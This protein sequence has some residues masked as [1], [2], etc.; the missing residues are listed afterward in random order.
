MYGW[1]ADESTSQSI[2]MYTLI[3]RDSWPKEMMVKLASC[4]DGT[5]ADH[6][7]TVLKRE[8]EAYR[9]LKM[10]K[11]A[12]GCADGASVMAGSESGVQTRALQEQPFA[13]RTWDGGHRSALSFK[14][15]CKVCPMRAVLIEFLQKSRALY[16]RA[17]ARTEGLDKWWQETMEDADAQKRRVKFLKFYDIRRLREFINE[18]QRPGAEGHN[19]I[20]WMANPAICSNLPG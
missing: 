17:P 1:M 19:T 10:V 9:G 6:L 8:L 12:G 14:A 16:K 20:C 5:D 3:L 2:L 4:S 11:S 13:I 15:A 7:F 18:V